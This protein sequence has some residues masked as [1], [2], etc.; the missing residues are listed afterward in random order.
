MFKDIDLDNPQIQKALRQVTVLSKP[1][2]QIR[3]LGQ[4]AF[5]QVAKID[6]PTLIIQGSR[7]KVVP[8]LR[9]KRLINGFVNRVEYHEVDGGHDLIDPQSGAWDQVKERVLIFAASL[10]R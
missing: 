5:M 8:P 1:I 4:R 9:T 2:E 7:D 10:R 3:Q 6:M